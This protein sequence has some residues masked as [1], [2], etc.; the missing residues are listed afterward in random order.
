MGISISKETNMLKLRI[1]YCIL[2]IATVLPGLLSRHITGIPLFA[3]DIL[4]G[5][6]VYFIVR[7]L[8]ITK[9]LKFV[10]AGSLLF[11]YAI[12]FSQLYRAPWADNLRHTVIGG[13][14][15]GETFLCGD[16][17]SY[18]IGV[19]I[20]IFVEKTISKN[21]PGKSARKARHS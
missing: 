2:V 16:M 3:G 13:L 1:V 21:L 19:G 5:L 8:F 20:G 11:C 15:L 14:I 9:P 6:M 4:W 18:T 10:I 12:E 7:F 17:L